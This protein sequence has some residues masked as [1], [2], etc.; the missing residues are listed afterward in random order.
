MTKITDFVC[1]QCKSDLDFY[2]NEFICNKCHKKYNLVDNIFNFFLDTLSEIN[3]QEYTIEFNLNVLYNTSIDLETRIKYFNTRFKHNLNNAK[4]FDYLNENYLQILE[5]GCGTMQP[6][7]ALGNN[8]TDLQQIWGIDISWPLLLRARE[9]SPSTKLCRADASALPF[10]DQKFNLIWARHMLYH[11]ESPAAVLNECRRCLHTDGVFCLSTNS[12]IN[13]P[14]MHEFHAQL[15]KTKGIEIVSSRRGSERFPAE[16]AEDKVKPFFQYVIK[17]SYQGYFEFATVN[18]F[19][20]YYISTTYFKKALGMGL[21]REDLIETALGLLREKPVLK[22]SN[23]G[24]VVLAT[25]SL[26][27]FQEMSRLGSIQK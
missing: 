3:E 13:K 6:L 23:D 4:I 17:C 26:N 2:V 18:E 22:L 12:K 15:L 10:K 20:E 1:P 24:A 8:Y 27:R 16:E 21:E 9:N 25:N 7:L 19:L 14:Q 11:V 5:V